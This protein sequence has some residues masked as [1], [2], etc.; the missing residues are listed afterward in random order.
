M[1]RAGRTIGEVCELVALVAHADG[2]VDGDVVHVIYVFAEVHF[3]LSRIDDVNVLQNLDD[4]L[5]IH[6][7]VRFFVSHFA[8]E[9][10]IGLTKLVD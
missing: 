8:P 2:L 3:P 4:H 5:C 1:N 9:E 7:S 10:E 6:D